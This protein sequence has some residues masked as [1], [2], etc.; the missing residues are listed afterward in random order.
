M[1]LIKRSEALDIWGETPIENRPCPTCAFRQLKS[2]HTNNQI[3]ICMNCR[4]TIVDDAKQPK[5]V[6]RK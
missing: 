3:L 2:S 5:M 6:Y 4:V 1:M